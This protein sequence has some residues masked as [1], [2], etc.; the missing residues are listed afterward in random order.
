MIVAV[1][2]PHRRTFVLALLS[3]AVQSVRAEPVAYL[4]ES[5]FLEALAELG[6]TAILEGFEEDSAWGSVRSTI[7]GG[8]NLAAGISNRGLHWTANN[9]TSNV[10][11]GGGPALTGDWG[12]Y[13]LPHGSYGAPDSG[14]DC[15]VSGECGDGWRGAALEGMLIAIGGWIKTNTP[16]AKL[17]LYLGQYP[18]GAV[19]FGETCNPPGGENCVANDIV[20]TVHRFWGVIDPDGFTNFEF[21]EL[22]GKLE[23]GGGDLKYLFADD[24][25]FAFGDTGPIFSDGFE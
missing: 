16:Y 3:M 2:G 4:D 14:S 25:W 22:E 21:R 17:G 24:F 15:Y 18:D 1:I 13:S 10:T 19:D 12:F 20:D 11:T 23:V 8:N 5:A 6:H 7:S 9:Q